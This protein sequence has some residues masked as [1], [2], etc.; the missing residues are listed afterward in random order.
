MEPQHESPGPRLP[1]N[2]P[3][4]APVWPRFLWHPRV[5]AE[6]ANEHLVFVRLGFQPSYDRDA[7]E[8]GIRAACGLSGVP[9]IFAYALFGFH[10][11]I[12]RVWLPAPPR[13]K[14][15][16]QQLRDFQ[17][18]LSNQLNGACL[19]SLE[20]LS[21]TSKRHFAFQD[22]R[23][24]LIEPDTEVID[25]HSD[26]VLERAERYFT[27][28]DR[29]C[30][31]AAV[32]CG[33]DNLLADLKDYL[34]EHT[35]STITFLVTITCGDAPGHATLRTMGA[36]LATHLD[37]LAQEEAAPLQ[38]LSLYKCAG[39]AHFLLMGRIMHGSDFHGLH[40]RLV[41]PINLLLPEEPNWHARTVTHL[42]AQRGLL[43]A[44]ER[45]T[46]LR[47]PD[48]DPSPVWSSHEAHPEAAVVLPSNLAHDDR[49]VI[50]GRFKVVGDFAASRIGAGGMSEVFRV[51]D[52]F[53]DVDRALKVFKPPYTHAALAEANILRNCDHPGVVQYIKTGQ[54][55]DDYYVVMEYVEGRNLREYM[56]ERGSPLDPDAAVGVLCRVLDALAYLHPDDYRREQLRTLSEQHELSPEQA[57]EMMS[58]MNRGIVHRDIK[59]ENIMIRRDGTVVLVDFG[60][61]TRAGQRTGTLSGTRD[62]MA[63]DAGNDG[64]RPEDDIFG[65]GVVLY[66]LLTARLPYRNDEDNEVTAPIDIRARRGEVDAYLADAVMRACSPGRSER[67]GT[68]R[69][70]AEAVVC[71]TEQ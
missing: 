33:G 68:A 11:L 50:G 53:A 17:D 20:A 65:C 15:H 41:A 38:Q 63:P 6:R 48:A 14:S 19:D 67:F 2:R 24:R 31:D 58:L 7:V 26:D 57:Q 1:A 56:S 12:I 10:D 35:E 43:I 30:H 51:H 4:S 28:N 66:E 5:H 47:L 25:R 36:A 16:D 8:A 70:F 34:G 69:A 29:A 45:L 71:A 22:E 64:W 49:L 44:E 59:P 27:A 61:A 23:G 54:H 46:G 9:S 37:E 62:Y 40:S 39:F 60:I 18:Q 13:N 55:E 42:V 3:R 32:T 21:A 52:T